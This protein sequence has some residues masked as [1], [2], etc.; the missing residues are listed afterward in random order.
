MTGSSHWLGY[1]TG[2]GVWPVLQVV[3]AVSE[4]SSRTDLMFPANLQFQVVY[5]KIKNKGVISS[6]FIG[7]VHPRLRSWNEEFYVLGYNAVLKVELTFR[8]N[9]SPLSSRSKSKPSKKPLIEIRRVVCKNRIDTIFPY[10][11]HCFP[12]SR[13]RTESYLH[14]GHIPV[15]CFL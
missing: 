7:S 11:V 13:Q 12:I 15:V 1:K 5:R 3:L 4:A 2:V 14:G 10:F 9:V 8:R 6:P